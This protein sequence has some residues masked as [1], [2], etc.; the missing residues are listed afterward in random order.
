M[1]QFILVAGMDY[2]FKGLDF[3]IYCDNRIKRTLANNKKKEDMRFHIFDFRRGEVV[4]KEVTFHSG[5]RIEKITK[6][7]PSPFKSISKA[8]Y[9]RVDNGSE[10]HYE[11]KDGQLD[12]MSI[13][14]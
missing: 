2:E 11:F 4:T 7:N 6:L 1:K 13:Q 5:K 10:T 9:N 14:D 8:N 3:R 12:K